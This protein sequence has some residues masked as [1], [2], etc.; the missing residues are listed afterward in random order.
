LLR[1]RVDNSYRYDQLF[2]ENDTFKKVDINDAIS[3]MK[4]LYSSKDTFDIIPT[5]R[6]DLE[7]LLENQDIKESIFNKRL[8]KKINN[9]KIKPKHK[10]FILKLYK[11]KQEYHHHHYITID[12]YQQRQVGVFK[13]YVST[14]PIFT[15]DNI[16]CIMQLLN[17]RKTAMK[18]R[19]NKTNLENLKSR[20]HYLRLID[21]LHSKSSPQLQ[22]G[23][24][25]FNYQHKKLYMKDIY[26]YEA[27]T[28]LTSINNFIKFNFVN[29]T[30]QY[31]NIYFDSLLNTTYKTH[32]QENVALHQYKGFRKAKQSMKKLKNQIKN[33]ILRTTLERNDINIKIS[34]DIEVNMEPIKDFIMNARLF[35]PKFNNNRSNSHAFHIEFNNGIDA[36]PY[37]LSLIHYNNNLELLK[38]KLITTFPATSSLI[39]RSI[40]IDSSLLK[41]LTS[42]N[43]SPIDKRELWQQESKLKMKRR[44][45]EFDHC[46][47][48]NGVTATVRYLHEED[49]EENEKKK[50]KMIAAR[51]KTNDLSYQD[52]TAKKDKK[53]EEEKKRKR[54]KLAKRK[55]PAAKKKKSKRKL[56][57][58]HVGDLSEEEKTY[59]KNIILE[60]LNPSL[61]PS[62]ASSLSPLT[63]SS[64]SPLTASS[65]SSSSPSSS[66]P[67]SLSP[68]SL[69]PPTAP[70]PPQPSSSSSSSS[71]SLSPAP[72]SPPPSE[73]NILVSDPGLR[74]L[75]YAVRLK[76]VVEVNADDELIIKQKIDHPI[77]FTYSSAQR[78]FDT[79][80][81]LL[82]TRNQNLR[83]K[84]GITRIEQQKQKTLEKYNL[85][86]KTTNIQ[87][88]IDLICINNYYA[89]D[90]LPLYQDKK[91][92][93][94]RFTSYIMKQKA[95]AKLVN[96]LKKKFGKNLTIISGDSSVTHSMRG[97]KTVPTIGL[98]KMLS[99]H[100]KIYFID[101]YNTSQL[102]YKDWSQKVKS[103]KIKEF[104]QSSYSVKT[105]KT[106][107]KFTDRVVKTTSCINRDY[108]ASLNMTNIFIHH[109]N[110]KSR[111][112]EFQFGYKPPKKSPKKSISTITKGNSSQSRKR[113]KPD[114]LRRSERKSKR[115]RSDSYSYND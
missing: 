39:A 55:K 92:I 108:N 113:K 93:N 24:F 17:N 110:G 44:N 46:I 20:I 48:T 88:Y 100:F 94:L 56:L 47:T 18:S 37:L 105:Y 31:V 38:L 68:S 82:L 112:K 2:P 111:P 89:K 62:T 36:Q 33:F 78:H 64:L 77:K 10:K 57:F 115:N 45:Y 83:K 16:K 69:S 58:S 43:K 79:R 23:K 13:N 72:S 99:N 109:L 11:K 50:K 4:D 49:Y 54:K 59:F 70:P 5:S 41:K 102:C 35:L 40:P 65:P 32:I 3:Y 95:D 74:D 91:F 96:T 63:A 107:N 86:T 60:Q 106:K 14:K 30:E 73:T 114:S 21:Y 19:G 8:D 29:R 12:E 53:E 7:F 27:K 84:L 42:N 9:R 103:W 28:I 22:L 66:S 97:R 67:S 1:K 6:K 104:Q 75:M 98:L 76:D 61:S 71:S 15:N 34:E 90:L 101:E 81:K 51:N 52:R 80:S 26:Q 87:K 85:C 25:S